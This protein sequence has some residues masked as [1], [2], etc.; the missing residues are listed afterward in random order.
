MVDTNLPAFLIPSTLNFSDFLG[1]TQLGFFSKHIFCTLDYSPSEL[2]PSLKN[3]LYLLL[4]QVILIALSFLSYKLR[5]VTDS[6]LLYLPLVMGIVFIHW[7]G[8]RILPIL[9][10]NGITT[11]KIYGVTK[12]TPLMW[13][14]SVH[15][16]AV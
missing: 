3:I 1:S 14:L 15:E 11:L 8:W 6:L 10:I 9:F 7:F 4:L 5:S 12:F 2:K 13:F 16:A